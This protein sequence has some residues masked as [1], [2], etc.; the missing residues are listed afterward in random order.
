MTEL[1]KE[2]FLQNIFSSIKV[3]V[4]IILL[5]ALT[6][7]VTKRFTAGFR[8]YSWLAVMIIYLIPFAGLGVNYQIDLTPIT[9]DIRNEMRD[10]GNWYE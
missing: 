8:Y 7:P 3:S 2:I 1:I 4:V 6:K 5:F 10:I 9:A